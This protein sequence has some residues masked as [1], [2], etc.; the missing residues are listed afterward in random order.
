MGVVF[1]DLAN[2]E[3]S[4]RAEGDVGGEPFASAHGGM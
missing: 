3:V 4:R 2:D 1:L